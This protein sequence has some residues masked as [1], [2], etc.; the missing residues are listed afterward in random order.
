MVGTYEVGLR[1]AA[2][3]VNVVRERGV[4]TAGLDAVV[5]WSDGTASRSV[6]RPMPSVGL[7]VLRELHLVSE[8]PG[9][10]L[11][12]ETS[13]ANPLCAPSSQIERFPDDLHALVLY[14][15]MVLPALRAEIA[16]ALGYCAVTRHGGRVEWERVPQRDRENPAW[17]WFQRV[18][19]AKPTETGLILDGTL[20]PYIAETLHP[21]IPLS[22]ADLDARLLLQRE[23]AVLAEALVVEIEKLRLSRAGVDYLA[24]A[25]MRVSIEDVSAGYDVQSFEVSGEPRL[26]EVKCS[27]GPRECFFLSA[28]E[29][30]MAEANGSR[31]W[32]AWIGWGVNLPDGIVDLCWVQ[33]LARA[34]GSHP[35]PWRVSNSGWVVEAVADDANLHT[36]P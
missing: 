22:Q 6:Q 10:V 3:I 12:F 15:L 30:D 11:V 8:R 23:R 33:N 13:L 35:S 17:L 26:I 5:S 1:E 32:L 31:Y 7:D 27:A 25:V 20:L 28:N 9:G 34:L 16:R 36:V 14:R 24:D 18:G 19:C 29:R 4:A 21:K 2:R